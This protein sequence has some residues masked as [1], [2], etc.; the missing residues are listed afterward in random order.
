[1]AKIIHEYTPP[2]GAELTRPSVA[3]QCDLCKG[4]T[5][6]FADQ[7]WTKCARCGVKLSNVAGTWR[8][9]RPEEN[10]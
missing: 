1:M 9:G 8:E 6:A 3:I 7:T 10:G 4:V 5:W 2:P